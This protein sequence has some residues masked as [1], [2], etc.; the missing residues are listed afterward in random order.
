MASAASDRRASRLWY[1]LTAILG[2]LISGLVVFPVAAARRDPPVTDRQEYRLTIA[3]A[4]NDPS[5]VDQR[6]YLWVGW[7]EPSRSDASVME[8]PVAAGEA[9]SRIDCVLSLVEVGGRPGG[10]SCLGDVRVAILDGDRVVAGPRDISEMGDEAAMI[11][12]H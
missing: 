10:P 11:L 3:P 4:I 1:A 12:G 7:G 2:A 9:P 5:D 6:L 8:L